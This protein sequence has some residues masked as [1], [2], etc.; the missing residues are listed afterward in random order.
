M[1]HRFLLSLHAR[2]ARNFAANENW[3]VPPEWNFPDYHSDSEKGRKM[4]KVREWLINSVNGIP[5]E[6]Q[7]DS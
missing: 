4:E 2:S 3:L 1:P 7:E 6:L 5:Q